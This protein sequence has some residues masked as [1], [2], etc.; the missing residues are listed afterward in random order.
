MVQG[1][2]FTAD[3]TTTT[4]TPKQQNLPKPSKPSTPPSAPPAAKLFKAGEATKSKKIVDTGEV[5]LYLSPGI[6]SLR[7]GRWIGSDNLYNLSD[8]IAVAVELVKGNDPNITLTEAML[9]DKVVVLFKDAGITP[10]AA[11]VDEGPHTPFFHVLVMVNPIPKGYVAFCVGRLFETTDMPRVKLAKGIFWQVITWEK[12]TLIVTSPEDLN[13][14]VLKT[15]DEIA[16]SFTTR[17]KY[18]NAI[19]T[20][21]QN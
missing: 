21:S 1:M 16:M 5:P 8:H 17:L 15:V 7:E 12:E 9:R 2:L 11:S 4:T 18:F 14:L 3:A 13:G 6:T 10:E 19:K 20:Q